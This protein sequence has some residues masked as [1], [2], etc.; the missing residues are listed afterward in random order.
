M[1]TT[2]TRQEKYSYLILKDAQVLMYNEV[3]VTPFVYEYTVLSIFGRYRHLNAC[4]TQYWTTDPVDHTA[5]YMAI[6]L[7]KLIPF[8]KS[9]SK[10]TNLFEIFTLK[11]LRRGNVIF[12][13]II[14]KLL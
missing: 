5:V 13:A 3:V 12:E 7:D 1:P 6:A 14:L 11:P 2:S 9:L 10:L 8:S 4:F